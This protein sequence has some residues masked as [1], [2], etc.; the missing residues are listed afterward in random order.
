[1]RYEIIEY[2]GGAANRNRIEF[3]H[4]HQTAEAADTSSSDGLHEGARSNELTLPSGPVCVTRL[5]TTI[6]SE[7]TRVGDVISATVVRDVMKKRVLVI[8]AGAVLTGRLCMFQKDGPD[9]VIGLEFDQI[10]FR[11]KEL[12]VI[13]LLERLG[14]RHG[15]ELVQSRKSS[16]NEH[17]FVPGDPPTGATQVMEVARLQTY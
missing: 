10:R 15:V 11:G 7:K 16:S 5:Q 1:V 3:T 13:A 4:C 17:V 2:E 14:R 9:Y 6:D 8:P 12:R